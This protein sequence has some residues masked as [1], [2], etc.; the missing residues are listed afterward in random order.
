MN[1]GRKVSAMVVLALEVVTRVGVGERCSSLR[2]RRTAVGMVEL[3]SVE[4]K[5]RF[6]GSVCAAEGFRCEGFAVMLRAVERFGVV[7][8]MMKDLWRR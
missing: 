5:W 8:E 7:R 3:S 6:G 2:K 4:M 1:G